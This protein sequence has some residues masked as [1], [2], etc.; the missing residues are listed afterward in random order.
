MSSKPEK[1]WKPCSKRTHRLAKA[2][3]RFWSGLDRPVADKGV[4]S[5]RGMAL[6]LV[7]TYFAVMS[8]TVVSGFM[9]SQVSFMISSNVR[10]DLKAY[11]K[12]KSALNLGRLML[13][14]QYE[15]EANEFFGQRIKRSNFQIYSILDIL[16]NPF[17]TG[18]IAVEAPGG[19]HTIAS[20]DLHGAGIDAMGDETG[21][22]NVKV[23]PEAGRLNLNAFSGG[24]SKEKLYEFCMMMAS[25]EYNDLFDV[26]SGDEVKVSR[27]ELL[28]AIID[29][30][31]ADSEKAF[32]NDECILE[33]P[34]GDEASLYQ[35]QRKRYKVKNAKFT[36]LDEL[37]EVAGFNDDLMEV[38]GET[39]TVY[40]VEK[41]NV[42]LASAKVMYSALCNA[43]STESTS[44]SSKAAE[45]RI[46]A[47]ADQTIGTQ[48]FGLAMALEGYQQYMSNPMN[49]IYLYTVQNETSVIPGVTANGSIIPFRNVAEYY[50]IIQ[51]MQTDSELIPKF[52]LY[53]PTAYLMLGENITKVTSSSLG[54]SNLTFDT[55]KLYASIT[56]ASPRIFR[57][58]AVGEYAGTQRKLSVVIDFNTTGGKFLYWREY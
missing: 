20:Y 14:Y 33:D 4:R 27:M 11:Y 53:S 56:T 47:C 26:Q 7:L 54:L 49:L 31:D 25:P 57:M 46:W 6:L 32:V 50:R 34:S 41:I 52:L 48:L 16:M 13:T 5:H 29:W 19:E 9:N 17:K 15:L 58:T 28:G 55:S 51:A 36:T 44:S 43:V 45:N 22:F 8:A 37:Y 42:N 35:D 30:V 23:V 3:Y 38:F 10:D 39:F 12:A 24:V 1:I 21:D 40:P 18:I 2:C